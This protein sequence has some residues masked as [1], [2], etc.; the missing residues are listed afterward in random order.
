MF[1]DEFVDETPVLVIGVGNEYRGDD[2]IGVCL[3]REVQ[4]SNRTRVQ[5]HEV[6]G[7]LTQLMEWLASHRTVFLFDALEPAGAPGTIQRVEAHRQVVS[8]TFFHASTHSFGV[9][10]AIELA[11]AL[12]QLPA[13]LIVYGVEGRSFDVG[14]PLSPEIEQAIPQVIHQVQLDLERYAAIP[15][16]G[17][18]YA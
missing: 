5:V 16:P 1:D 9:A 7:E 18:Y 6:S 13:V 17:E 11:R 10:E 3:A 2:G 15:W 4:V 12:N 14:A 8:D